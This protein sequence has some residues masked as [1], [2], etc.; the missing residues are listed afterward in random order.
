MSR[1]TPIETALGRFYGRD[2]IYL[3]RTAFEDGTNVL[4]LEGSIN[5]DLCTIKRSGHFIPYSLRFIGVLALKM[6]ELDSWD[7]D[8]TSCFDETHES[9]WV[10]SLGGKVSRSHRHFLVQTY[11]DVF[12]VICET[13]HFE[14][15]GDSAESLSRRM[16]LALR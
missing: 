14:V 12:E 3:D 15:R 16:N 2:C 9:E 13:H 11:D 6:V 4:S 7:G 10:Q 8:C 1:N 5:G